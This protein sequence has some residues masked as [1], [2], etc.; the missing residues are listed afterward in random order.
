MSVA[1]NSCEVKKLCLCRNRSAQSSFPLARIQSLLA[2]IALLSTSSVLVVTHFSLELWVVSLYACVCVCLCSLFNMLKLS[3]IMFSHPLFSLF[4]LLCSCSIKQPMG[5]Q[6]I[7][8]I[9]NFDVNWMLNVRYWGVWKWK[10]TARRRLKI[11]H[12]FFSLRGGYFFAALDYNNFKWDEWCKR[13]KLW[14][15]SSCW[16]LQRG[17]CSYSCSL[18][19]LSVSNYISYY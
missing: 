6:S 8:L 1:P 7:R 4:N 19:E 18:I 13:M 2:P 3:L 9:Y 17:R 10:G 11:Y 14:C 16:T 12:Y 15:S 5:H